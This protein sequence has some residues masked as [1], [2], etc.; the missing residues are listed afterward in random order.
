M[1]GGPNI[2]Y[3]WLKN[4][5][6]KNWNWY[7]QW[8]YSNGL[9][10]QTQISS[11]TRLGIT[12]KGLGNTNLG[13]QVINVIHKHFMLRKLPSWHPNHNMSTLFNDKLPTFQR[14]PKFGL[15]HG[16]SNYSMFWLNYLKFYIISYEFF[17]LAKVES[18]RISYKT[19]FLIVY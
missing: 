14:T 6:Q 19:L 16:I 17:T 18:Q 11:F 7:N 12:I 13:V 4:L 5:C 10:K 9:P 2:I 15:S 3:L 8:N 1:T